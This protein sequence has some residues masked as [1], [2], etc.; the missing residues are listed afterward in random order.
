VN[1][2]EQQRAIVMG[3]ACDKSILGTDLDSM[4]VLGSAVRSAK[5]GIDCPVDVSIEIALGFEGFLRSDVDGFALK[6][7]PAAVRE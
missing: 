1:T 3:I 5:R 4:V 7:K 2:S 6:V